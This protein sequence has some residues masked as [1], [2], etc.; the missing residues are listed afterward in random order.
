MPDEG[1]GDNDK[2]EEMTEEMTEDDR[3]AEEPA[4]NMTEEI[5]LIEERGQE[6]EG[7][8]DHDRRDNRGSA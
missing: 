1:C 7:T 2:N 8:E 4:E 6:I 5:K 3:G